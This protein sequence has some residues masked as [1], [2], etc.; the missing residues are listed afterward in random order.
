MKLD[1]TSAH[2]NNGCT[3]L[4]VFLFGFMALA[5][6][7][8]IGTAIYSI[9]SHHLLLTTLEIMGAVAIGVPTV[10]S[11]GHIIIR[12][13]SDYTPKC[14]CGAR[15]NFFWTEWW[16]KRKCLASILNGKN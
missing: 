6:L 4:I 14:G 2:Y 16:H 7:V 9:A 13:F 10:W 8:L 12:K 1:T 15:Y 3:G 5:V 11:I